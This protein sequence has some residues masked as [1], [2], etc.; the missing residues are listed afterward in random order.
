MK[1]ETQFL[2]FKGF[3]ILFFTYMFGVVAWQFVDVYTTW[4]FEDGAV[5][6]YIF[7]GTLTV[8]FIFGARKVI[9]TCKELGAKE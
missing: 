5:L 4:G 3:W 2:L 6:A 7:L 1:E 9:R 8:I